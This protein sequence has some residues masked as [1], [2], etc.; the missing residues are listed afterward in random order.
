MASF[1]D[2]A[3]KHSEVAIGGSLNIIQKNQNASADELKLIDV[4]FR[5]IIIIVHSKSSLKR[6]GMSS[7]DRRFVIP[8]PGWF[9]IRISEN[10]SCTSF[11]TITIISVT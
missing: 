11:K 9:I 5:G 2:F 3:G 10:V 8:S 1:L 6:E 4:S 7:T